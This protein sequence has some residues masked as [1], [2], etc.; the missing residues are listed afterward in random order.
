MTEQNEAEKPSGMPEWFDDA[1]KH[2]RLPEG[3]RFKSQMGILAPKG[4]R[5]AWND[6]SIFDPGHKCALVR[7]DGSGEAEPE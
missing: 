2:D 7:F 3:W 6:K 5:W 1:E 4:W